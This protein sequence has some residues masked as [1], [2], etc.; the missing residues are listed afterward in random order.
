[1]RTYL[2]MEVLVPM[3]QLSLTRPYLLTQMSGEVAT[4]GT[5][6]SKVCFGFIY[7]VDYSSMRP[8]GPCLLLRH[9]G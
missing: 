5:N 8:V 6:H 3:A 7:D 9:C 2:F 1:M 4:R